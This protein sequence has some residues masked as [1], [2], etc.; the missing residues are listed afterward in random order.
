MPKAE[1]L[2]P[3]SPHTNGVH[4]QEE[5][6]EGG[7]AFAEWPTE[8]T[9]DMGNA[10]RLARFHGAD[11]HYVAELGWLVWEGGRWARDLDGAIMRRADDAI[12]RMYEEANTLSSADRKLYRK[13]ILRTES[14]ARRKSMIEG[15]Q[16]IS[17]IA[18][19]PEMFDNDPWLLNCK[20]GTVDLRTGELGPHERTHLLSK[21]APVDYDPDARCPFWDMVLDTSFAGDADLIGFFRRAV[22]YTLTGNTGEQVMF[23]LFGT[24]Q[25][26]KS[27]VLGAL[28]RLLGEY[29]QVVPK[30]TLLV[31]DRSSQGANPD[32]ARMAGAR[33]VY[34]IETDQDRKL[35]T[36]LIKQ[37][38][39]G[40]MIAARFLNRDFFQFKPV[41]KLW[42]A[43]NHKPIV[44]DT[45]ESI[46][47][48]V[49]LI[50]FEVSIRKEDQDP[51]LPE[52]LDT[53]APGILAWAVRGCLEWQREGLA[54]PAK[55][56]AATA[57]YRSEMDVVQS[58]LGEC[59][60]VG[61]TKLKVKVGELY[62]AFTDWAQ[63]NGEKFITN[64]QFTENMN[65]HG[66]ESRLGHGNYTFWHG[67]GMV[68]SEDG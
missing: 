7:F 45:T 23:L 36:A 59:C 58:F 52:M 6:E 67:V 68:T 60:V 65:E 8:N 54:P 48:R 35:A 11:L 33:L 16:S 38:T 44:K 3:A 22:G 47:R 32:V 62:K 42:Y 18:A 57:A 14:L 61:D 37:I 63:A 20:N 39:G 55:V 51:Y 50:P 26:G 66:F 15:A 5:E 34:A 43:V 10:R 40:D 56:L 4:P 9:T 25:N 64:R 46:W 31:Q 19:R 13:H 12:E 30:E 53:E 2:K 21:I 49:M 27:T 1:T 28:Q 17:T 41:L 24:G 29:A